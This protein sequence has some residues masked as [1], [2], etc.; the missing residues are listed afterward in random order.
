MV[1]EARGGKETERVGRMREREREERERGEG[2]INESSVCHLPI[3]FRAAEQIAQLWFVVCA[4]VQVSNV[5]LSLSLCHS[6]I[7]WSVFSWCRAQVLVVG[8]SQLK[9]C[10]TVLVE[11]AMKKPSEPCVGLFWGHGVVFGSDAPIPFS[12]DC[13]VISCKR[14][15]KIL[16]F[17]F[18][19]V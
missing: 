8:G 3:W 13:V 4:C 14:W 2:A 19:C 7:R 6:I 12:G 15:L 11:Q 10:Q 17:R 9:R 1:W 16:L 18:E 5:S